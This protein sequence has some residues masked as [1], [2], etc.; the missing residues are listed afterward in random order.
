[1]AAPAPTQHKRKRRRQQ[2]HQ[3][4]RDGDDRLQEE[5]SVRTHF[6][7]APMAILGF[8]DTS[9]GPWP[10][11]GSLS[12]SATVVW[13]KARRAQRRPTLAQAGRPPPPPPLPPLSVLPLLLSVVPLTVLLTFEPRS[14][15]V[16]TVLSLQAQTVQ[17][18]NTE[19]LTGNTD[20]R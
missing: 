13:L 11:A 14:S 15:D 9:A 5:P 20:E 19:T 6:S 1:V 18:S 8:S 17:A 12:C 16:T 10:S 4:D 2:H 7:G 3:D